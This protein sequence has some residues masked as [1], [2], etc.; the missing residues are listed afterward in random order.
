MNFLEYSFL[1]CM[2]MVGMAYSC[3]QPIILGEKVSEQHLRYAQPYT[4]SSDVKEGIAAMVL[5]GGRGALY[6][7][8]L[9]P[10]NNHHCY[11]AF[12]ET[13]EDKPYKTIVDYRLLR[14]LA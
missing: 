1:S 11:V 12:D 5:H 3:V 10:V 6:V 9:G 2:C 7:K 14:R 13:C 4:S 8:V